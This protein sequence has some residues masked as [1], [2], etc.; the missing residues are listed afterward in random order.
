[1]VPQMQDRFTAKIA[2]FEAGVQQSGCQIRILPAPPLKA[3]VKTVD[4][5]QCFSRA[6]Q[7]AAAYTLQFC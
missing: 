4:A 7:M 1:M 3:F 2:S 5:M 6:E